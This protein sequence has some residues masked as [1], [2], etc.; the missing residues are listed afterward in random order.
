MKHAPLA[1]KQ[2]VDAS[3]E[4]H[5]DLVEKLENVWQKSAHLIETKVKAG[6]YALSST[7]KK[8]IQ[9]YVDAQYELRLLG[10]ANGVNFVHAQLDPIVARI[11]K[12]QQLEIEAFKPRQSQQHLET[13][14]DNKCRL[15]AMSAIYTFFK[16]CRIII[17]PTTNKASNRI[18]FQK[19][20]KAFA[21]DFTRNGKEANQYLVLD[22]R[23]LLERTAYLLLPKLLLLYE[24]AFRTTP[25]GSLYWL[26]TALQNPLVL[27]NQSK[28]GKVMGLEPGIKLREGDDTW[29]NTAQQAAS[30]FN[31]TNKNM[32][33]ITIGPDDEFLHQDMVWEILRAL[34]FRPDQYHNIFYKRGLSPDTIRTTIQEELAKAQARV[35][36]NKTDVIT[37][38]S[39]GKQFDSWD[40]FDVVEYGWRNYGKRILPEDKQI[41]EIVITQLKKFGISPTSLQLFADIGAGPNLYASMLMTPYISYNAL[42]ELREYSPNNRDYLTWALGKDAEKLP[43]PFLKLKGIWTK[44]EELMDKMNP[45]YKGSLEKVRRLAKPKFTDIRELIISELDAATSFFVTESMTDDI[46]EFVYITGKVVRSVKTGGIFVLTHMVESEGY[47]A[48]VGTNFPAVKL[49]FEEIKDFYTELLGVDN[50]VIDQAIDEKEKAR[51]G[52]HGMA[53]VVGKMP[54]PEKVASFDKMATWAINLER[55]KMRL[56]SSKKLL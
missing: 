45:R 37:L 27:V 13:D 1:L 53:I 34:G 17:I 29:T 52:Y 26:P 3:K 38:E 55:E 51:L 33:H 48:G 11:N 49:S 46:I 6:D 7:E 10:E 5:P 41:I 22:D 12:G 9:T 31:N 36:A 8:Q 23:S 2:I 30:F 43:G 44:F 20:V 24:K 21:A 42:V 54:T 47:F 35:D 4:S 15:A 16:G 50:F 32:V 56:V 19:Q 18:E 28:D 40:K 39:E 25:D 14:Q